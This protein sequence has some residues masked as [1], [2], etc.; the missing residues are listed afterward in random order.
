MALTCSSNEYRYWSSLVIHSTIWVN[1]MHLAPSRI[2]F[3]R[4]MSSRAVYLKYIKLFSNKL[5][6]KKDRCLTFAKIRD[7]ME[8]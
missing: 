6:T 1:G 4:P 8:W 3:A 7:F 5:L 2:H